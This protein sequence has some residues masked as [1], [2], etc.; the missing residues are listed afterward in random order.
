MYGEGISKEGDIL[1]LAVEHDIVNKSGS[2]YSYNETRLGQGRETVKQYFKENP[3]LCN[4]I[5]NKVRVKNG[6]KEVPTI[7]A[8]TPDKAD[9]I[10]PTVD[11]MQTDTV[12][13]LEPKKEA[14]TRRRKAQ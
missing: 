7:Q 3:A 9:D 2:W 10:V 8:Q 12:A 11:I 5:E 1:D 6:I 13:E 4:E 14:A